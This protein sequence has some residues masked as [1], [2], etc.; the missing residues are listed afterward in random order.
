MKFEL[1]FKI[2]NVFVFFFYHLSIPSVINTYTY[3][4][5]GSTSSVLSHAGSRLKQNEYN[6]HYYICFS[7]PFQA[8]YFQKQLICLDFGGIN[9]IS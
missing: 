5:A 8:V 3:E 7:T 1:L 6:T 4:S 2:K 9:V